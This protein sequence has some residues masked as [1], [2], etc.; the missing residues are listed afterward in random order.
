MNYP[1]FT[2]AC[3]LEGT[4]LLLIILLYSVCH[5]KL[6][7]KKTNKKKTIK[8]DNMMIIV[9]MHIM[10]ESAPGGGVRKTPSTPSEADSL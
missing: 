5:M 10:L 1:Y 2:V 6:K 9:P 3:I 7:K 8:N 4:A